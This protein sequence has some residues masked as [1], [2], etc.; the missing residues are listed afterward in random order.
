MLLIPLGPSVD[1]VCS[2]FC[3]TL[4]LRDI[5]PDQRF[6]KGLKKPLFYTDNH[7]LCGA[8]PADALADR[9]RELPRLRSLTIH[10]TNAVV[11]GL[12]WSTLS[13]ILSVPHLRELKVVTI[14]FCPV[15]RPEEQ[16]NVDSLSPLTSFQYG[17]AFPAKS[18]AFPAE[19]AA[20][21]AVLGKLCGTLETLALPTE[22]ARHSLGFTGLA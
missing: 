13:A 7:L 8:F 1:D 9:L 16:L 3:S 15:L 20:L 11:H 5:C 6:G 4:R 22:P 2:V 19:T 14:H 21:A 18:E 12:P 10:K 17:F